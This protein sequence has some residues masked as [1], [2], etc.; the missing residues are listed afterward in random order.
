MVCNSFYKI[1]SKLNVS[2]SKYVAQKPV[3]VKNFSIIDFSVGQSEALC[4][5]QIILAFAVFFISKW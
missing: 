2:G 4:Y 5:W 3:F 1:G